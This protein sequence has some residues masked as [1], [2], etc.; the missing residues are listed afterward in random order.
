MIKTQTDQRRKRHLRI[1]RHLVGSAERPRLTVFRSNKHLYAQLVDDLQAKTLFSFSTAS[2]KFR[3]VA[4]KGGLT[5]AVAQKL[6]EVYGPEIAA[7]KIKKI[8]FDR[9]GYQYH[10]R[11]KALAESLRQAGLEF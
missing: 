11:V 6:G 9:A 3:K 10:G 5:V 2:K 8:V 1:R 7:K 4:P